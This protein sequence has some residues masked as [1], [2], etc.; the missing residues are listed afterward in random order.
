MWASKTGGMW[1][2]ACYEHVYAYTWTM[3][4]ELK[5]GGGSGRWGGNNYIVMAYIVMAYIVMDVGESVG[6]S[7][8]TVLGGAVGVEVGVALGA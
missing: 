1:A 5:Q 6:S 8:G 2:A 7:D 3:D 4:T